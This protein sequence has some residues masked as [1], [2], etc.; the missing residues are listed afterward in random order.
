MNLKTCQNPLCKA[1]YKTSGHKFCSRE[2]FFKCR[3]KRKGS[4][5]NITE[6]LQW[7]EYWKYKLHGKAFTNLTPYRYQELDKIFIYTLFT[8]NKDNKR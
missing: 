7:K 5:R 1:K 3:P 4:T 2:C 6:R 8:N